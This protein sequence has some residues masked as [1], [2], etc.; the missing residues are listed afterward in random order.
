MKAFVTIVIVAIVFL[1]LAIGANYVGQFADIGYTLKNAPR[2][3]ADFMSKAMEDYRFWTVIIIVGVCGA[4][5]LVN[6]VPTVKTRR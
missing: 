1:L 3:V 4:V 6:G 5:V 2:V